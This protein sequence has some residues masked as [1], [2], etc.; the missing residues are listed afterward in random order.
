MSEN[1]SPAGTPKTAKPPVQIIHY[2][3]G[4]SGTLQEVSETRR[5]WIRQLGPLIQEAHRKDPNLVAR[6][7]ATL[8]QDQLGVFRASR[9]RLVQLAPPPA[10]VTCHA[11]ALSW[12]DEH[13]TACERL[14]RVGMTHDVR[15]LRQAQEPLADARASAQRINAEYTRLVAE[16]RRQMPPARARPR[17]SW[18]S[19]MNRFRNHDNRSRKSA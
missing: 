18:F 5:V 6:S 8:G 2:L 12:L 7:A 1:R 16:L 15:S 3:R 13:I 19:F 10:C 11:A 14:V 17:R 4:L 9:A